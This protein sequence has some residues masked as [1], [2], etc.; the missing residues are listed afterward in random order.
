MKGMDENNR[1]YIGDNVVEFHPYNDGTD[2]G[3]FVISDRVVL[4]W[5]EMMDIWLFLENNFKT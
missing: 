3:S 2:K 5:D 4:E 1:L